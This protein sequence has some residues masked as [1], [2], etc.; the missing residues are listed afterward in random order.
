M[1]RILAV[2]DEPQILRALATNLRARGYDVD[3][4]ESGE[5]ALALAARHHPDVVVLDLGLPGMD[6][7]DARHWAA[8]SRATMV[9]PPPGVSSTRFSPPIASRKPFATARPSPT[10]SL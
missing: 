10:P 7:Q 9:S 2:D 5:Q 6:G 3:L 1:T 4:A 8:F